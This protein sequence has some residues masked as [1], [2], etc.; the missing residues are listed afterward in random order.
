MFKRRLGSFLFTII[1]LGVAAFAVS[2]AQ[3]I[4]DYARY[5]QYQPSETMAS[6]VDKT[7]MS[8][9]G[10]FLFYLSHPTLQGAE[11]FNQLC[12]KRDS[13]AAV[14]GCYDGMNIYIYDI[15]DPR[16]AGIRPTTAAHEMLH[17][18]Y[19]RLSPEDKRMVDGLLEAEYAK[20][21]DDKELSS[22]MAFYA[23]TQPG[24]RANELHSIIG[25]EI[26]K[27]S[28]QLEDY[29]KRYFSDRSK[30]IAQHKQYHSL[31]EELSARADTLNS[32]MS[33]LSEAIN[34]KKEMYAAQ[35]SA[36]Q[37]DIADFNARAAGGGF[38][39]QAEFSAERRAL[40][41][42]SASLDALR[43]EIN[44]DIN[45]YNSLVTELNSIA[46]ETEALN[47]SIDSSLEPAPSL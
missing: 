13:T 44:N 18:A 40:M 25:T 45:Y 35:S 46:V 14:L 27:I 38:N 30:V 15:T 20:L 42:R 22:R 31:F 32:Q 16:L 28:S 9:H 1:F 8:E 17:A 11:T 21:K 37:S 23:T 29:Y 24:D 43:T 33:Q 2:N 26:G 19:S 39:S 12:D 10:E 36:L 47:R 7:G 34:N 6:F 4:G 5:Y 41:A 3:L